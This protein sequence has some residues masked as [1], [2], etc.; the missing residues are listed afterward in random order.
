VRAA[1]AKTLVCAVFSSTFPSLCGAAAAAADGDDDDDDDSPSNDVFEH[2]LALSFWLADCCLLL[3]L[4]L[5][6]LLKR[7]HT[8]A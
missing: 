1:A 7:K 6:L 8:T 4:L 2:S 5:L 3:L